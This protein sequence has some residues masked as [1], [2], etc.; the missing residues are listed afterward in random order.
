MT[1][2]SYVNSTNVTW[3]AEAVAFVAWRDAV[4]VYAFA[5]L[6]KVESGERPRP[7]VAEIVSELPPIA[8]PH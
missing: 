8:W 1:C 6:A 5:E 3:A 7:S 4:W 2:S